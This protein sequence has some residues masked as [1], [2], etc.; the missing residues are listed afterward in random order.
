MTGASERPSEAD[1]NDDVEHV[2][3]ID[4]GDGEASEDDEFPSAAGGGMFE[5]RPDP[6]DNGEPDA[7]H[8]LRHVQPPEHGCR[9]TTGNGTATREGGRS[10]SA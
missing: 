3:F 6:A 2:E 7:H 4:L 10:L 1:A 5:L 9:C 8:Q